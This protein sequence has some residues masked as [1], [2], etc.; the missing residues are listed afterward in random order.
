[1]TAFLVRQVA[2]TFSVE[3]ADQ[4]TVVTVNARTI[5][6]GWTCCE[7]SI[8][9]R[10]DN[11]LSAVRTITREFST[12]DTDRSWYEIAISLHY[13]VASHSVVGKLDLQHCHSSHDVTG[14]DRFILPLLVCMH[15]TVAHRKFWISYPAHLYFVLK[16]CAA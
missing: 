7:A 5:R 16:L 4:S 1:M 2:E 9:Q 8:V 15:F 11:L 12:I 10:V 6:V 3:S 14:L 13:N